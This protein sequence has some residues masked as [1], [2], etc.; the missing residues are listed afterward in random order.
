MSSP[1]G[2]RLEAEFLWMMPAP[3]LRQCL[4]R[5]SPPGSRSGSSMAKFLR[6]LAG[7]TMECLAEAR[8]SGRAQGPSTDHTFLARIEVWLDLA[9]ELD[10]LDLDRIGRARP[11]GSA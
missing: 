1:F 3:E 7:I 2:R 8:S 5:A 11:Q 4:L 9:D 10:G 6:L